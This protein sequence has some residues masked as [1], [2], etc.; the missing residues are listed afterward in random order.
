MIDLL[1]IMGFGWLLIWLF[2]RPKDP[3]RRRKTC[4]HG[5]WKYSGEALN[6]PAYRECMGCGLRV[7]RGVEA[8]QT[9]KAKVVVQSRHDS[10]KVFGPEW[11]EP[12]EMT[13]PLFWFAEETE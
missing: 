10:V 5:E 8:P 12:L 1:I 13:D 7:A 9:L 3:E 11:G 4:E 2:T 6:V